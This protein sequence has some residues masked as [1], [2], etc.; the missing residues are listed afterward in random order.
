MRITSGI[1]KNRLIKSPN[2]PGTH[3]MG[4]RE[5][6]ALFNMLES[7]LG[8]KFQG[9]KVLDAFAG[10]GALGIEALSR[11]AKEV[12]FVENNK[13]VAKIIKDNLS[14]IFVSA[15]RPKVSSLNLKTQLNLAQNPKTKIIPK[16]VELLDLEKDSFDIIFADPPYDDFSERQILSLLK[17]LKPCGLFVLSAP[18]SP[19][20]ESLKTLRT[21]KYARCC[22]T[23][24]QKLP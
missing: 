24:Y 2:N 22:I 6:L 21:R 4:E 10:S 13:A 16:N 5:R 18:T 9:I 11:G 8:K 15:N 1:Y 23:I 17:F 7:L 19:S 20:L 14:S 12:V 3:P